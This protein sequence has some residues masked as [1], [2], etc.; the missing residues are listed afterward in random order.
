[1]FK[2]PPSGTPVGDPG[3]IDACL[4]KGL[5]RSLHDQVVR[6]LRLGP[7]SRAHL[8]SHLRPQVGLLARIT[9]LKNASELNGQECTLKA[10][11]TEKSRWGVKTSLLKTLVQ[12]RLVVQGVS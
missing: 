12:F 3:G 2:A 7:L 5:G 9:G 8:R 10:W 6:L 4:P 1:M 11:D